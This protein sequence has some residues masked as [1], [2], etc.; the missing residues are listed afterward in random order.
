MVN[1]L[2][3]DYEKTVVYP[4]FRRILATASEGKS[5]TWCEVCPDAIVS[6]LISCG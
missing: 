3:P 1:N 6:L 5:W 2:P 4:V